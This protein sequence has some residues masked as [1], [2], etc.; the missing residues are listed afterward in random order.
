[1]GRGFGRVS[2]SI[3]PFRARTGR[4]HPPDRVRSDFAL[5]LAKREEISRDLITRVSL[6][7]IGQE[8]KRSIFTINREVKCNGGSVG[9][10]DRFGSIGL[11]PRMIPSDLG[12]LS[13][14]K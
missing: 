13:S 1:M 8:R 7:S 11:G 2:S 4:I 14:L 10:R 6:R 5:T 12:M 9:Y 3:Y